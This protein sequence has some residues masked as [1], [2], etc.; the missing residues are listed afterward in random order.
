MKNANL[1]LLAKVLTFKKFTIEPTLMGTLFALHSFWQ[2]HLSLDKRYD[3][4]YPEQ[5]RFKPARTFCFTC[6]QFNPG[7]YGLV[8][9]CEEC[10]STLPANTNTVHYRL[11]SIYTDFVL[12]IA[13]LTVE[14]QN[15]FWNI[16]EKHHE[17]C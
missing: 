2:Q 9:A 11:L 16:V 7:S 5:L 15:T 17:H 10:L 14:E 4:C 3:R 6:K 12:T 1:H 13:A 8:Y